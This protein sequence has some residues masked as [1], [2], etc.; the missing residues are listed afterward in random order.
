M[1]MCQATRP[2]RWE[3]RSALHDHADNEGA[4]NICWLRD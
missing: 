1:L 2:Q 4:A 3:G